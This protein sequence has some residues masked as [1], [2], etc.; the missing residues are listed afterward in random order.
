MHKSKA[1]G[2]TSCVSFP[3][4]LEQGLYP[5]VTDIVER[6]EDKPPQIAESFQDKRFRWGE[7]ISVIPPSHLPRS[8]VI[9]FWISRKPHCNHNIEHYPE[10]Q[11]LLFSCVPKCT[12]ICLGLA[13]GIY[14]FGASRLKFLLLRVNKTKQNKLFPLKSVCP[15]ASCWDFVSPALPHFI[16]SLQ[17]QDPAELWLQWQITVLSN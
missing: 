11:V 7:S 14:I 4:L 3:S 6:R 5:C 17:N 2:K 13:T 15:L 12:K 8:A 10:I 16:N 1:K 9:S